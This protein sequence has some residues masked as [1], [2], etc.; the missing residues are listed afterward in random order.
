M[1]NRTLLSS[2]RWGLL[3]LAGSLL[4]VATRFASPVDGPRPLSPAEAQQSFRLPPGFKIELVAS[5]PL[6]REPTGVCWDERGRLYVSELHGYNLE[7]QLEIEDLNKTGVVDTVVRRI[8]AADRYKKAA[9]AGTYGTLKR[10]TDTNGDGQMDRVEVMADHLPPAY[11][12]CAVRGGIL[13]AGQASIVF[14]ADRDDDGRAEVVDTL[15][16]G[17][18]GGALERGLNAPQWG[19]DGW[20]YV[21]RGWNGGRITG[22]HLKTPVQLPGSN[23]RIRPDG[24]AIEPVTGSTHTIGHACTPDGDQFFTNTWKHAL[25]A[26]PIPWPYL[27]RNPDAVIGSL[28]GDASD[29]STVYPLAPVHPWKLARSNQEEWRK[30]YDKYGLAESAAEGYF[31]SSCS[32]LVYQD[33]AFPA[34]FQHNLFVCEPAQCLVHRCLIESD[35]TGL[36]VRRAASEQKSEFLASTDSWFRPVSLAHA[37]DGSLYL[38]DMYREIIEDYSAVPRFM[39]QKYGLKNGMQHGR[40]WRISR[41]TAPAL[42]A[43]PRTDLAGADL[44]RELD[45]PH[46]WH[47][48]TANRLLWERQGGTAPA[49]QKGRLKLT[50]LR[51]DIPRRVWVQTLRNE[52][53]LLRTDA[54]TARQLAGLTRTL[55]DERIL[56]QLAL[57]LGYSTDPVVQDALTELARQKATIR[58]MPDALLTGAYGRGGAILTALLNQPGSTGHLLLDPLAASVAAHRDAAEL[59]QVLEAVAQCANP[60]LQASTLRGINRLLKPIELPEVGKATLNRLLTTGD[61]AVRGQAATLAGKLN[62]SDLKALETLREQAT[63]DLTNTQLPTEQRLAAVTLLADANDAQTGPALL[64][65]WPTATPLLRSA[66]LDALIGRNNRISYLLGALADGRVS[67]SALSPLQRT[68]LLERADGHLRPRLEEQFAKA[69]GSV[70]DKEAVF[71]RYS[72]ALNKPTNPKHGAV[73]FSQLCSACHKVGAVGTSVGPDLKNT[74]ANSPETL[75]RSILWPSEKIASSYD[76]YVVTT[77]D[78]SRY[79]GVVASESAGSIVLRNAG[80]LEQTILRKEITNL[81]TS[82]TSLMPEFG[83]ALNPQDCADL[84]GWLRQSLKTAAR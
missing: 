52:D 48:E 40:I 30:Y 58:W 78:G 82:P 50:D 35:G 46:Y 79:T 13:I 5:E 28:E 3:I 19:N 51:A 10:L 42:R 38:T 8:Q 63:R 29:Y 6:I 72:V 66:L 24:S 26:I 33:V 32:P 80:G 39:Q 17:F 76:T 68:S 83:P 20:V 67:P 57:S 36:R 54:A 74:Y 55:T 18:E 37:P 7:G 56:L 71:A 31:T 65:A 16:T 25:Y 22:P 64:A 53:T 84:I 34:E 45:S 21:G 70:G 44:A 15:F 60:A 81:T 59:T 14:V 2:N 41:T 61:L 69:D 12:L 49:L 4:A 73:L 77:N 75:V 62:L 23:F 9:E 47:R 1:L 27:A 43:M 11:G